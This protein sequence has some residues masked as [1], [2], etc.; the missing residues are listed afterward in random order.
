M[1]E[2][3]R[4]NRAMI[5]ISLQNKRGKEM[6][7][8]IN[9][10]IYYQQEPIEPD[11]Y[12]KFVCF[13]QAT[14]EL[15][16]RRITDERSPYDKTEAFISEKIRGSSEQYSKE[17]YKCVREYIWRKTKILF[18][19]NRWRKETRK[20]YSAQGWIEKFEYFRKEKDEIILDMIENIWEYGR[21]RKD[22][23]HKEHIII[24]NPF[25][26]TK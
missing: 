21:T 25:L 24:K 26:E 12:F 4:L 7:D 16:D 10:K 18:D 13:Y 3:I 14:T 19:I 11:I 6:S 2:C 8:E 5:A 23:E 15:F 1:E 20:Q 22:D 17:L 9:W